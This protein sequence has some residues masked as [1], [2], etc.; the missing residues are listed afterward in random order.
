MSWTD[1]C[2]NCGDSRADCN[3]GDYNGIEKKRISLKRKEDSDDLI[4]SEEDT[5][6]N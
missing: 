4:D 3:C 6:E 1:P 5:E 2:S